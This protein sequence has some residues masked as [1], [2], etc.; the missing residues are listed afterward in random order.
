MSRG[1]FKLELQQDGGR[2]GQCKRRVGGGSRARRGAASRE[3]A[4]DEAVSILNATAQN[5]KADADAKEEATAGIQV[6]A[7]SAMREARIENM[8][9]AKGYRDC[10]VF[11]NDNGVNVIVAQPEG[12]LKDAD[13]ARIKD[14]VMGEAGV[15]ADLIKIVAT[16]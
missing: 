16:A 12:G 6:M 4:R 3:K 10:V 1:L 11:I 15:T 9:I 5:D 2:R 8:V 13:V 14:I 7:Q